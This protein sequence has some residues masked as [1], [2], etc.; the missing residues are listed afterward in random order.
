MNWPNVRTWDKNNYFQYKK[1]TWT[2][3][4][5]S[6]ALASYSSHKAVI[7]LTVHPETSSLMAREWSHDFDDRRR[8]INF[9]RKV[10]RLASFLFFSLKFINNFNINLNKYILFFYKG[11][12]PYL[13]YS[14]W[15]QFFFQSFK[16]LHT[17]KYHDGTNQ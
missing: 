6:A 3:K 15:F 8:R 7:S 17:M 11:R 9:L 5:L 2:V 4:S 12:S 16:I 13:K 14:I 1:F 10:A